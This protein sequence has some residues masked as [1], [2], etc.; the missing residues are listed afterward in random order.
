M[1]RVFFDSTPS[2]LS[3][4]SGVGNVG[5]QYF[6]AM[7]RFAETIEPVFLYKRSSAV[8][9][10]N[11]DFQRRFGCEPLQSYNPYLSFGLL[12]QSS[13]FHSLYH[14]LPVLPFRTKI[15]HVNDI[16]TIRKNPYQSSHF[17]KNQSKKL[18]RLIKRADLYTVLSETVKDEMISEL[19]IEPSRITVIGYGCNKTPLPRADESA[20]PA[21]ESFSENELKNTKYVL[22]VGRIEPRKN[23]EHTVNAVKNI[24]DLKL[25]VV[26]KG[27]FSG[28]KIIEENFRQLERENRLVW[29]EQIDQKSLNFL[30]QHAFAFLA[31]SWEEG[32]GIPLLEAMN[33]SIP[34]ITANVSASSEVVDYGGYLVDPKHWEESAHFLEELLKDPSLR[35]EYCQKAQRRSGDFTW[36]LVAGRLEQLYKNAG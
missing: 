36:E 31:P 30:Y 12:K 29:F 33:C 21:P 11:I 2:L 7:K 18:R 22:F 26:G 25:V 23:I 19:G 3:R 16:W 17:Q 24:K 32:L 27:G 28:R 5:V 14:K 1:T 6:L 34:V 4:Y 15:L 20:E 35:A 13:V 8:K 9:Q 10:E